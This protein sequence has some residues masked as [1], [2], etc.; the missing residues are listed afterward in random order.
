LDELA[1]ELDMKDE[2]DLKEVN[3]TRD[4]FNSENKILAYN[5]NDNYAALYNIKA[6]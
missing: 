6:P 5:T 2:D 4:M 1:A 3:T